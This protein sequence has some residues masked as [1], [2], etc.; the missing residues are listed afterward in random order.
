MVVTM[1]A[2]NRKEVLS[3]TPSAK[4]R[5]YLNMMYQ[6]N[7]LVVVMM[8]QQVSPWVMV[9]ILLPSL[10]DRRITAPVLF[11]C[12]EMYLQKQIFSG[13]LPPALLLELI[14][15]TSIITLLAIINTRIMNNTQ[16]PTAI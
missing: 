14:C 5:S 12:R 3:L 8:G 2:S 4:C 16:V 11:M 15:I 13:I 1:V 7:N 10:P 6:A 9:A